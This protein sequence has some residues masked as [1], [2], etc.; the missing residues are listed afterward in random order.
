[1]C[2]IPP[3]GRVRSPHAMSF[4]DP[5]SAIVGACIA[6]PVLLGLYLLKLRRRPVRV[7]STLLW[8][9]AAEDAQANVPLRWL[10]ASW[11]LL[12][13]LLIVTLLVT[14]LGRPTL[15]A[16]GTGR[17]RV[18]FLIDRSASMSCRDELPRATRLDSAKARAI[19]LASRAV[20]S[21]S[22]VS[23][24]S[25]AARAGVECG[26][27]TSDAAVRRAIEGI[28][29]TDQ[30][31]ELAVALRV[32]ESLLD[33]GS[34]EST[35]ERPSVC[36]I[37]DGA[38]E[39]GD[40]PALSRGS[41]T[42]VPIGRAH[43]AN[44]G[45]VAMSARRDYD[46]PGAVRVFARLLS[47]SADDSDVRVSLSL[48]GNVIERRSLRMA[49]HL[50]ATS[51]PDAPQ[52]FA[53]R[54]P[55]AVVTFQL[56]NADGGVATV[57]IDSPDSLSA[58]N[59]AS[60][61]L[62]PARRA[63]IVL[64]KPDNQ[65]DR[66]TIVPPG[67]LEDALSQIDAASF[68][69]MTAG[70]YE[71]AAAVGALGS[72]DLFVFDRVR[73]RVVPPGAS[74]SFGAGLPITGLEFVEPSVPRTGEYILAWER[75]HPL[76]RDVALDQV[77]IAS[78]LD[79]AGPAPVGGSVRDLATGPSGPL[80]VLTSDGTYRRLVV[81][82]DAAD[83]NWQLQVSFAVFLASAVDYLTVRG[84]ESAGRSFSTAEPVEIL[85]PMGVS[86]VELR[87]ATAPAVVMNGAQSLGEPETSERSSV[88]PV[89]VPPDRSGERVPVGMLEASGI[90]RV[91]PGT[92]RDVVAVNLVNANE[93]ACA[94]RSSV[95]VGGAT[96]TSDPTGSVPREVWLWFVLGAAVLLVVEWV[97]Y[98]VKARA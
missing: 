52:D 21:G 17:G 63:S 22:L 95:M 19:E 68:V 73:P 40:S 75:A 79:H 66:P 85:V 12:L 13:H 26:F 1:M 78:A 33:D 37:S 62:S 69:G 93:T 7:S 24:V 27:T 98:A 39:A 65:R 57:T 42:F 76:L 56:R 15:S 3:S 89:A 4:L 41:V 45:I 71:R 10:R 28:T 25:F 8:R 44:I 11:L 30:P 47:A 49:Q 9:A 54:A 16:R 53:G 87:R 91:V 32:T 61:L 51:N 31:A 29:P 81:A 88:I 55:E 46:D 97:L 48:D 34:E 23:V 59:S 92:A 2:A 86:S 67:L 36:L 83:S 35:A 6:V 77:F 72:I 80:M 43:P 90:Y 18:V 70:E 60:I 5:M 84:E 50:G 58:D 94:V 96:V 82:F 20:E 14:A 64:V 38:F 74:L